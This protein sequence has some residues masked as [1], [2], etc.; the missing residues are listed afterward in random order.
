MDSPAEQPVIL[1]FCPGILG[2]ER[3]LEKAIGKFRVAA[4]SEIE[5]FICANLIAGMEAGLLD[6]VPIWTDLKTFPAKQFH[7]KISGIIGGYPCQPFSNAGK[8]AGTD[9]PR[10]LFPYILSAI[11][12]IQPRFCFFENVRGHLKLGYDAV[13]RS[14]RDAGYAVECG[15]Y[16]AQ[17]VGA[18][19]RRERLF[20]LAVKYGELAYCNSIR[21]LHGESEKQSGKTD[22]I[23]KPA[24]IESGET[25]LD[26]AGSPKCREITKLGLD[27]ER[28]LLDARRWVESTNYIDS[29]GGCNGKIF[30]PARPGEPQYEWE[31]PRT[32]KPGVGC[33]VNGYNFKEDLLRALGNSVVEQ[34][35]E[36]AFSDLLEKHLTNVLL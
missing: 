4:Y 5:A 1:A 25:E 34:T 24:V 26:Y 12:E 28:K 33:S 30:W 17:E 35:A 3:G 20:I 7:G 14:L 15:I 19:H 23:E 2:L 9:D 32:V 11:R 8:Q 31:H 36:F 10:H 13:Y 21:Y 27:L 29:P 16:S 18:P 22:N 6:P